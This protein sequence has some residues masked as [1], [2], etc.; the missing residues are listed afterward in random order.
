MLSKP[1]I[2]WRSQSAYL[3]TL[4]AVLGMVFSVCHG[5]GIS[6]SASVW[7]E[8]AD[9]TNCDAEWSDFDGLLPWD[10]GVETNVVGRITNL[11]GVRTWF[12]APRA[13]GPSVDSLGGGLT[14]LDVS[15]ELIFSP[16]SF[17]NNCVVFE[18]GGN[19]DGTAFV[20]QDGILEFRVQDANNEDQRVILT[21][22]FPEE[23]ES[24]FYH[25]VAT[26][27][28]GSAEENEVILYINGEKEDEA[29]AFGDLLDWSGNNAA[30]VGVQKICFAANIRW[31][32]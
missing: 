22:E 5:Q 7:W 11:A 2:F 3:C 1:L 26:V 30:G 32:Q 13:T 29:S 16:G 18:T 24:D 9:H 25:V 28:L 6:D 20:V 10:F 12:T 17:E 27:L 21:Y 4:A 23:G 31:S 19:G 15:W 14:T 8:A